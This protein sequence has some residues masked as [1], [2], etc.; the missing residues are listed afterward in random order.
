MS[1]V[2]DYTK[3]NV[4]KIMVAIKLSGVV[5]LYVF[6]NL[7]V[8]QDYTSRNLGLVQDDGFHELGSRHSFGK[9][10]WFGVVRFG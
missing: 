3:R 9:Q 10:W 5:Q 8:V 7:H 6:R 1:V 2:Q 4:V